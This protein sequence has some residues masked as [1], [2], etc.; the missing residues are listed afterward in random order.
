MKKERL[1]LFLS[2]KFACNDTD[3]AKS[4]SS[5]YFALELRAPYSVF[6]TLYQTPRYLSFLPREFLELISLGF[7]KYDRLHLKET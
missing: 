7:T 5:E 4:T 6:I 2:T 1:Q 3:P